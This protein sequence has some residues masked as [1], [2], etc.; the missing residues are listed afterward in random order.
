MLGGFAGL[1]LHVLRRFAGRLLHGVADVLRDFA[2]DLNVLD[3]GPA[4]DD[5]DSSSP[6][7]DS[8]GLKLRCER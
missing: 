6:E 8:N 3:G 1:V 2:G 4:S 7:D 5:C